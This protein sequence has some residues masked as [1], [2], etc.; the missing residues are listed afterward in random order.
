[1]RKNAHPIGTLVFKFTTQAKLHTRLFFKEEPTK[2]GILFGDLE[3]G[4]K[5]SIQLIFPRRKD[6]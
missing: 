2:Y 3:R 4:D 1:M 6:L 5:N